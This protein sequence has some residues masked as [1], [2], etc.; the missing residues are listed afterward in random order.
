MKIETQEISLPILTDKGIRLFIKRIDKI[1]KFISGNKWYKLK[2]NLV[3]AQNNGFN[4]ILTFGGAYSNHISATSF[5][6]N[7]KQLK[8]IGVIR[9]EESLPLNPTLK[10]AKENGMYL[11]YIS[12]SEYKGKEDE[13]FL[14][15]LKDKFGNFYLIPEGGTN[16][17]AIM[18]SSE[19]IDEIDFQDYICCSVGTG[20]TISG[21]INSIANHQRVIGFPAIKDFNKLENNVNHWTNNNKWKFIGDYSFGGFAKVNSSLNEFIN[22]FYET[23]QIP[24]DAIYTGKMMFGIL[25]LIEKDYFPN[26]TTILAIHTGGIQGN[27]GMNDRFHLC[28]PTK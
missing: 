13:F 28:L 24:L 8:S 1:N 10:F 22:H 9:G 6:A 7:K 12:R 16:S 19:I 15:E 23:Q 3:E 2:Y 27:L 17:L 26:N 25:D 5:A 21:I 11:H 14:R 18:G 4:Q 20:G